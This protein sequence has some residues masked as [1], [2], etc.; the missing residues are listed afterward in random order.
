MSGTHLFSLPAACLFP[1]CVNKI[2][3]VDYFLYLAL[4]ALDFFQ[5]AIWRQVPHT[6]EMVETLRHYISLAPCFFSVGI[7]QEF[8]HFGGSLCIRSGSRYSHTDKKLTQVRSLE[9]CVRI[10]PL[11]NY[12]FILVPPHHSPDSFHH[13]VFACLDILNPGCIL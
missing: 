10:T 8:T 6:H 2:A 13:R 7:S 12:L 1:G 3:N 11:L 9:R 5:T 4:K